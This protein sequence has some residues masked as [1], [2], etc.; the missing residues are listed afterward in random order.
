MIVGRY[1]YITKTWEIGHY[2]GT[3]F[4]ILMRVKD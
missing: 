1:D 3:R 2:I 4:I